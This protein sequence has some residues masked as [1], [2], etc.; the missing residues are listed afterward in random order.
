M[1]QSLSQQTNGIFLFLK[2]NHFTISL[3]AF[4]YSLDVFSLFHRLFNQYRIKYG[5]QIYLNSV[6]FEK[7]KPVK[8]REYI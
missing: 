1:L 2:I 5:Y 4:C 3:S 7:K 6:L 8:E